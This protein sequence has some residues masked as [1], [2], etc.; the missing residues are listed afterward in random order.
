MN[1]EKKKNF[2]NAACFILPQF[3]EVSDSFRSRK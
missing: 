3:Y 1:F 2:D